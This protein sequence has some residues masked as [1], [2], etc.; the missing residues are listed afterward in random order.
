MSQP[1]AWILGLLTAAVA[2][3]APDS[4]PD[5]TKVQVIKADVYDVSPRLSQLADS[6]A[7]EVF[8]LR[9]RELEP[10]QPIPEMRA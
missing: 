7:Q 10:V 2:A 5:E 9:T 1:R 3:C 8:G 6:P 4:T